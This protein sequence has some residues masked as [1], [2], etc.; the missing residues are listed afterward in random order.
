VSDW[1]FVWLGW[2]ITAAVLS[3]YAVWIVLRGR[4]VSRRVPPEDRR[5]L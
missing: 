4:A 3:S 5:W 1:G 2:G